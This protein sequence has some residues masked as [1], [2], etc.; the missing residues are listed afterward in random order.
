VSDAQE[1]LIDV[2]APLLA[3]SDGID[4]FFASSTVQTIFSSLDTAQNGI[5][6]VNNTGLADNVEA[7]G[8]KWED[9]RIQATGSGGAFNDPVSGQPVRF[10]FSGLF[11][12]DK[13]VFL[14]MH[15][16]CWID[17]TNGSSCSRFAQSNRQNSSGYCRF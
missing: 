5:T 16:L 1:F 14:G 9:R 11:F 6:N 2:Q 4:N 8:T 15:C 17:G 7:F 13:I 12:F 3:V 10:F